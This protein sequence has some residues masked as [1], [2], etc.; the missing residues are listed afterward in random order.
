MLNRPAHSCPAQANPNTLYV[1]ESALEDHGGTC[2]HLSSWLTNLQRKALLQPQLDLWHERFVNFFCLKELVFD[3]YL[4][5]PLNLALAQFPKRAFFNSLRNLSL[6]SLPT[7]CQ[8]KLEVHYTSQE[9]KA[10][11]GILHE[12]WVSVE[13]VSSCSSGPLWFGVGLAPD[14]VSDLTASSALSRSLLLLYWCMK[15]ALALESVR[16]KFESWLCHLA[17]LWLWLNHL[18]SLSLHFLLFEICLFTATFPDCHK[19]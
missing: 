4:S 14:A 19:C 12:L 6:P 17:A 16:S 7:V 2:L 1:E 15:G 18:A 9:D 5:A 10:A 8:I 3:S 11:E 13:T